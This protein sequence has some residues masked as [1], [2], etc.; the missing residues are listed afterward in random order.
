MIT[1]YDHH[2]WQYIFNACNP[3]AVGGPIRSRARAEHESGPAE[4]RRDELGRPRAGPGPSRAGAEL[5]QGPSRAG[6]GPSLGPSRAGPE[7]GRGQGRSR[8]E[9]GWG[10][11]RAPA[12]G[13]VAIR[14]Y[15]RLIRPCPPLS[16]HVRPYPPIE[17][18]LPCTRN[19]NFPQK[20][21]SR[22]RETIGFKSWALPGGTLETE[23][24]PAWH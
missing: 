13:S 19:D 5:G 21:R 18:V 4:A 10:Q 2:I 22:V 8:P 23:L 7:P 11:G 1:I 15:P 9:P 12:D 3:P 17:P 14:P 20:G 16:A 24:G 6:P